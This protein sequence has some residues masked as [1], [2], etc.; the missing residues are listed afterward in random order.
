MGEKLIKALL[1]LGC[2]LE[3]TQ[4]TQPKEILSHLKHCHSNHL[5][6]VLI[7]DQFEEF[8]FEDKTEEE[9]NCFFRFVE[10]CLQIL[11][12]KVLFALRDDCLDLL[13]KSSVVKGF[14]QGISSSDWLYSLENF[15]PQKAFEAVK[16]LTQGCQFELENDLIK[17]LVDDLKIHNRVRPIELQIA[18]AQLQE[19][20]IK[21]LDDYR[22]KVRTKTKLIRSY[23]ETTIKSCGKE[24]YTLAESVI[25]FL[26]VDEK[27]HCNQRP[28][29]SEKKLKIELQSISEIKQ[30]WNAD[31][32]KT[33]NLILQILKLSK[34]VIF[35]LEKLNE[36]SETLELYQLCHDYIAEF[37]QEEYKGRKPWK[38]SVGIRS[39]VPLT[40]SYFVERSEINSDVKKLLLGEIA[41][42]GMLAIGAIQGLGGIGK[43]TLAAH[44]IRDPEVQR[45]FPDGILW[46]TLGQQPDLLPLLS[47]WVRDL[48]DRDFKPTTVE[49]TST[50]LKRLLVD[51]TVLLVVDD[52]WEEEHI[53]PFLVGNKRSRVLV[54][55]RRLH[56]AEAHGA[57]PYRLDFMSPEQS[58][59]LFS[60]R[61]NC[62]LEGEEKQQAQ[63]MAE[64][65]G[66]LPLA[67]ELA[68]A[69]ISRGETWNQLC[70]AFEAEVARLEMLEDPQ[71]RRK[72]DLKLTASFNLSLKALWEFDEA[73]WERFIWLGVLPEDASIAAPMTS[74]LW[75]AELSEADEGLKL[76]HNDALLLSDSPVTV[77]EKEWQAYRMHDLVHDIA[78]NLLTNDSNHQAERPP[79]SPISEELGVQA[80]TGLGLTL[81]E[82]HGLLLER[83]LATTPNQLWHELADDGYIHARLTWHIEKAEKIDLLHQ[84]LQEETPEEQ[85]GWYQA[86]DRLGRTGNFVADVAR[87]WGWAGEMYERDPAQSISLQ[88]R[89]ALIFA[90]LNNLASN[91]PPE[92]LAALVRTGEWQPTQ[93]LAYVEQVQNSEERGKA[94]AK[95]VPELPDSLL[96]EA[97]EVASSIQ[98]EFGS[99]IAMGSLAEKLP[100]HWSKAWELICS[101]EDELYRVRA[102][103]VLAEKLP[104]Y[105]LPEAL[106]LTRSIKDEY[107]R[108]WALS[109]LA[110]RMPE[111]LSE[112]WE[113]TCSIED[114]S[115]RASALNLLAEKLP[116][117]LISEALKMTRGIEDEHRKAYILSELA[118]NL[119]RNWLPEALEIA[120]SIEDESNLARALGFLAHK[121]PELLPEARKLISTVEDESDRVM[122]LSELAR[123]LPDLLPEA[124]EL[125]RSIEY[126][127]DRFIALRILAKKLPQNL[128]PEALEMIRSIKSEE[129]RAMALSRLAENLPQNLL[130]EAVEITRFIQ[131][132][133]NRAKA[134]SKLV[135]KL[136]ELLPEALEVTRSI[137]FDFERVLA[138]SELAEKLPQLL[139][140]ALEVA[141]SIQFP[142]HRVWALSKL[143]E[144][145][146]ELLAEALEVSRSIRSKSYRYRALTSFAEKLP[147]NLLP[148]ALEITRSFKDDYQKQYILSEL[149]EKLPE[150]LFPEAL[151]IARSIK[152]ESYL[153]KA[154]GFLGQKLPELLSEAL[155]LMRSIKKEEERAEVLI[156][157]TEKFPEFWRETLEMI[158]SLEKDS[159]RD[160]LLSNLLSKKLPKHLLPEALEVSRSIQNESNRAMALR[161]LAEKLPKYLLPEALEIT[162][163]I[164][165]E[166]HRATAL[167]KLLPR[168]SLTDWD[169]EFWQENLRVL[170]QHR[171]QELTENLANLRSVIEA[172]GGSEALRG[173][174]AAMRDISRQWP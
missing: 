149:A 168:L 12:L 57:T 49:M 34:L 16:Q 148:E 45:R 24:N 36:Q 65:V 158:R 29:K 152:K 80:L 147:Q 19:E 59:E 132:E 89:Y 133:Y 15:T 56:V 14:L 85:N 7:F 39:A 172:L 4:F 32:E 68:A 145:S 174:A 66:Y 81:R 30:K 134:L 26:T 87:A 47:Q 157:L 159:T 74:T 97:L 131:D 18:G 106:E 171:R 6:I 124:W 142:F 35:R 75:Q 141:R 71:N 125:I 105:L 94:L 44:L 119:P 162:R 108:V 165:D 120:R 99:A 50:H 1:D 137:E 52:A 76:L 60:K 104:E 161:E 122:V 151:E 63:A 111:L 173:L 86:C 10:E 110:E 169:E 21:T 64:A 114:E 8:F 9:I 150:N 77:G 116:E 23:L 11:S 95:L 13:Y 88:C 167:S 69:R 117:H 112:T 55:T 73:L 84:L 92:L 3:P 90:T 115:D 164:R 93:G 40:P 53:Q 25:Y 123:K 155:E 127:I 27:Q 2:A 128:H 22:F 136:P 48:D 126:E 135:E 78:R 28:W 46:T 102:L 138:L 121:F 170:A 166:Y 144:K 72:N 38:S 79:S 100:Q 20:G 31:S 37:I 130:S 160:R 98:N 70:A 140:E 118:E 163:S 156:D 58:L 67:L 96:S 109:K 17:K 143:A 103:R 139:P 154:L 129:I 5:N 51:K 113:L 91:I 43:T 41:T 62:R 42:S 33:V 146:P 83:Y 61:L 107:Y 153:A 54:T 82:A 101:I